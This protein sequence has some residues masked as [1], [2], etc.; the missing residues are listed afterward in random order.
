MISL[1]VIGPFQVILLLFALFLPIGLFFI[2]YHF[3]KKSGYLKRIKEEEL[4][5]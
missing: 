4:K 1:G 5:K 3:G 2:G